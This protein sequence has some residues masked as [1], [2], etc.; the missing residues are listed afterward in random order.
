MMKITACP[1]CGSKNIS[2]GTMGSGITFG[3]TSWN[4]MCKDCGYQGQPIVFDS[5]KKYKKFL[6]EVK[7]KPLDKKTELK[8][9]PSVEDEVDE[10][11][12]VSQKDK[13]VVELLQEYE[14]EKVGKPIWPK[15]KVWWPEIS[16]ALA[17]AILAY[18]SGLISETS[19]MGID[20]AILYSILYFAASFVIFLFAIVIIE[21]F[22]RNVLN[23]LSK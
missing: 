3:I 17:L 15:N 22:L 9:E 13:D 7:Q 6:V 11:I 10:V 4:E 1:K 23:I 21:Y 18:L 12:D 5:E 20:I 14:K 8:E 16:V 19:R 2:M